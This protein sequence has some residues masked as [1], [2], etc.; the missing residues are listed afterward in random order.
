MAE[1]SCKEISKVLGIELSSKEEPKVVI[2][3]VKTYLIN[4]IQSWLLIGDNADDIEGLPDMRDFIPQF[5]RGHVIITSRIFET[6]RMGSVVN[7]WPMSAPE[8]T[9]LL[10]KSSGQ[11]GDQVSCENTKKLL[12]RLGYMPVMVDQCGAYV[13]QEHITFPEY[14]ELYDS[15]PEML[16]GFTPGIW[17]YRKTKGRF[18]CQN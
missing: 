18:N 3:T 7:V 11:I 10:L 2:R 6:K 15:Q 12:D 8:A 16:L 1:E 5:G 17:E 13:R 14:L 9:E 4:R